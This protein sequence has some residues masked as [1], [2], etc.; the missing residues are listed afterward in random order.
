MLR[1]ALIR[2]AWA[3]P[4]VLSIVV[5]NFLII[6][7]VPG[8]PL[9]AIVGDF[10]APPEYIES[11]KREFGLD[12]PL[13][14]QLWLYLSNLAQGNLGF[15]FANRQPVLSLVVDRAQYTLLLMMP[16]L[17]IAAC[18]GVLLALTAA[19]RAGSTYD[20]AITALSLAGYSMPIFWFGQI[21]VVIFAIHLGWLPAQGMKSLR[22]PATGFGL[23]K[24]VIWHMI[25]PAFGVS[26]Y[27]V[28]VV[29]R[30]AR[31]SI[32]QTLHQDFVLTAKAKGMSWRY[33]MFRHVLP[34]AII[35]VVTVI[36]YNFGSSLTGA[37][38]VESVF[39]WPGLG[40]LFIAS[41]S[42]RDYPVLQGIFLLTGTTVVLA[43]L[44]TDLLYAVFDPRVRE[45]YSH[46]A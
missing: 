18:A 24:D 44:A 31:A 25:L 9:Q 4:I 13:L 34:N 30:V 45:S 7:L 12:R 1:Y 17:T 46:D 5:I 36:G 37:I 11:V 21:L 28:A 27:Y 16:A 2:F 32:Y 26:I 39:A 29:S 38:L 40:S 3:G 20:G 14:T 33:T 23:V 42:N 8:D 15:S 43:N 19:P 35:P 22:A 10:P 41:I 6:H